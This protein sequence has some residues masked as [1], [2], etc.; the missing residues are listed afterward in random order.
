VSAA[1][2]TAERGWPFHAGEREA[3]RR[4]GSSSAGGG[5]RHVMPD[6]HRQFFAAL[7]FVIAAT[8]D[9]SGPVATLW[10]GAAGFILKDTG[11]QELIQ[12]V[13]AVLDPARI[14]QGLSA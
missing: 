2:S 12:A 14:G 8:A 1:G 7:P 6:Q 9:A 3:Q 13:R 4:A 10:A 11:P 5:I